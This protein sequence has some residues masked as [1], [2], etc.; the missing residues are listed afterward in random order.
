MVVI[1]GWSGLQLTS[2][3]R[4]PGRA[5]Q[6][7]PDWQLLAEKQNTVPVYAKY[8]HVYTNTWCLYIYTWSISKS[9]CYKTS[10]LQM[11]WQPTYDSTDEVAK[12]KHLI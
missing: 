4:L 10:I 6:F 2:V 8:I 1:S 9:L 12:S 7:N 5:Y 11:G 3:I